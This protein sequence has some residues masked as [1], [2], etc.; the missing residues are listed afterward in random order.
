MVGRCP[1]ASGSRPWAV[2]RTRSTRTSWSA[3]CI[4]DGLAPAD[5]P[6]EADLIVVNTCAFVE[7]ARQESIDTILALDARRRRGAE[8]VVTGCLA[9]RYGDELAEALPEVDQVAPFGVPVTARAA[10]AT[11]AGS[12]AGA[13]QLRPAQPA[14]TAGHRAL[15]L[16]EG[17]RGLRPG[18]RLL[19]HPVLPRPPAVPRRAATSWPRS[20]SWASPRSC[21]SPR[22]WPPTGATRAR[23]SGGSCRWWRRCAAR[24]PRVRLLYLYPSDLTTAWSTPSAPPA[25]P[26][27][28]CRC[29][30]SRRRCCAACAAGATASASSAASPTSAAGSP[31]AA[32]RS[33]F[34]VGYPGETE[35]DHDRLLAFV[36]EAQLDWCGFFAFS[37]EEGT[38]AAG[39]DGAVA[40]GL[41]EE[42][43][44]ELREL[45]D[46]ITA[47]RRDALVG[48]RG[49]GAGRRARAS[50]RSYREAPEIDGIVEVPHDLDRSDRS[51]QVTV[52]GRR[53]ARTSSPSAAPSP[54]VPGR[55]TRP[56]PA[57][58][59]PGAAEAQRWRARSPTTLRPA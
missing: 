17:G 38:Y 45:Q 20:T 3:R 34:I 18:L 37:P 54:P 55:T 1:A 22:T 43:L 53:W 15:G 49:R 19:R 11:A 28:T 7:E 51:P 50:A 31:G 58:P 32:F 8:L 26:T 40:D 23:A 13:V 12:T 29:S 41:V 27:S 59:E 21:S 10:G 25:C 39:L 9:E 14:P 57:R 47:A 52:V 42:R 48:T 2:P 6:D 5:G 46:A 35:A 16:R 30:T 24:V 36:E 4:A 44:A 33:N 56:V